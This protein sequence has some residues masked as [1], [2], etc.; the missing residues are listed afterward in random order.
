M[1]LTS[2]AQMLNIIIVDGAST[3]NTVDIVR[4]YAVEYSHIRW[5]SDKDKG[6]S[7]AMNKGIEMARGDIISFLN[8]DDYYSPEALN[9]VLKIFKDLPEPSFL[10]G[11]CN[12]LDHDCKIMFVNK[13]SQLSLFD[14]LA[15]VYIDHGASLPINPSAYFYHA[16]LHKKTGMYKLDEHY[17][18]D[19]DFVIRTVQGATSVYVNEDFGNFRYIPNTKTFEDAREGKNRARLV[20]LSRNYRKFLSFDQ[21]MKIYFL[22]LLAKLKYILWKFNIHRP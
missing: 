20:R 5:I 18:M 22:E 11:N 12:V 1:L 19:I 8:A 7:D 21:L 17:T 14:L 10:V 2:I 4:K 3:D 6:Q 15:S 13:P 16:S 9:R